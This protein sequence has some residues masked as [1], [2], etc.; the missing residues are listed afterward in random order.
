MNTN[1]I[2]AEARRKIAKLLPKVSLTPTGKQ[3]IDTIIKDAIYSATKE[4]TEY[5]LR[6]DEWND[7]LQAKLESRAAHAS[8][9][10]DCRPDPANEAHLPAQ[11][12]EP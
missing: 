3:E 12:S 8:E 7:E 2:A 4:M 9:R 6:L 1:Q 11:A 5:A 10:P